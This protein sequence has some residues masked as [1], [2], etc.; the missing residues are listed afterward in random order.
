MGVSIQQWRVK[1]GCNK[2]LYRSKHIQYGTESPLTSPTSSTRS[3]HAAGL[4][5]M[6]L[7]L[8]LICSA[9]NPLFQ[10]FQSLDQTCPAKQENSPWSCMSSPPKL[11]M[12]KGLQYSGS[13][14]HISS[15]QRN[16]KMRAMNGNR[17]SRGIRLAHWNAGSAHLPNKM[18]QL[19]LA[20][21]DHH[22]HLL[23]I[24]EADKV[25]IWNM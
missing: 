4:S 8:A 2:S 17:E 15:K 18:T 6:I 9:I 3:R 7:I 24:S 25:M 20:V 10:Q 13:W 1:I 11:N 22:P 14:L 12:L 5:S 19:E 21:A 23:G 16:Q